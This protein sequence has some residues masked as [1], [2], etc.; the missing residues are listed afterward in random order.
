MIFRIG[1]LV[2]KQARDIVNLTMVFISPDPAV[3]D[4]EIEVEYEEDVEEALRTCGKE[5]IK[6]Y[7]VKDNHVFH[8]WSRG[9][10]L[11]TRDWQQWM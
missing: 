9:Q 1:N 5:H 10:D 7:L 2:Y 8:G 6:V 4:E 11:T 3:R